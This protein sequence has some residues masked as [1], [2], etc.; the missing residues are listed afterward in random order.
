MRI[1]VKEENSRVDTEDPSLQRTLDSP[2][3]LNYDEYNQ[4]AVVEL[5]TSILIH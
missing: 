4:V 2:Y 1:R 5:L 3:V